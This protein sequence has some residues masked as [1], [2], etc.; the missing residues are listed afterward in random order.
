VHTL[1]RC[2]RSLEWGRGKTIALNDAGSLRW[3]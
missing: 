3:S 2:E 1:I